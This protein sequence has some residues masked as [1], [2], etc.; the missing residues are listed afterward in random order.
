MYILTKMK[1]KIEEKT[2]AGGRMIDDDSLNENLMN[3]L[4][5]ILGC[6]ILINLFPSLLSQKTKNYSNTK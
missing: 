4:L 6:S 2:I 3:E 5:K 1:E